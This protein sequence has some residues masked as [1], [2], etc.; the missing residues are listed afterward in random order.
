MKLT[1]ALLCVIIA[2]IPCIF[3]LRILAIFP[4][5]GKSHHYVF[6]PLIDILASKGHEVTLI[7]HF[8]SKTSIP[9][10]SDIGLITD[11]SKSEEVVDM[12]ELESIP[13]L[14]SMIQVVVESEFLYS[15]GVEMC[16]NLLTNER[17]QKMLKEKQKFDIALVEQ[18]NTDCVLGIAHELGL[19]T[20]GITADTMMPWH[21]E[22]FG[23]SWNPSYAPCHNLGY[24]VNPVFWERINSLL[25]CGAMR[26]GYYLMSSVPTHDLLVQYVNKDMPTMDKLTKNVKMLLVNAYFPING[27]FAL[28]PNV[29]EIGGLHLN[30]NRKDLPQVNYLNENNL[31][32]RCE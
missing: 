23:V 22:R 20:V 27:A 25:V 8:P 19:Q 2:N 16:H 31:Y 29:K 30:E 1:C 26:L 6:T 13:K 18:F 32:L 9:N 28:P 24:G 14:L 12:T 11:M 10:R 3:A 5:T 17:V 7:S 21:F 15:F 4:Y